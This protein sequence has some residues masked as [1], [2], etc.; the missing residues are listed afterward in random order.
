MVDGADET[1]G[2]VRTAH[3]LSISD[4]LNT[5]NGGIYSVKG[6]FHNPASTKLVSLSFEQTHDMP[7]DHQVAAFQE[8]THSTDVAEYARQLEAKYHVSFSQ[9][10]ETARVRTNGQIISASAHAPT[11]RELSAVE[12]A[13]RNDPSGKGVKFYFLNESL[14]KDPSAAGRYDLDVDGHPSVFLMPRWDKYNYATSAERKQH[15]EGTMSQE[16]LHELAHH[17]HPFKQPEDLKREAENW[18][19]LGWKEMSNGEWA[20]A[21]RDGFYYE[22]V[23]TQGWPDRFL[24]KNAQGILVDKSGKAS[25]VNSNMALVPIADVLDV[26]KIRP[27][28]YYIP[29]PIEVEAEALSVY[30]LDR[31]G[32]GVLAQDFKSLYDQTKKIDQADIDRMYPPKNGRSTKIRS[33]EGPIVDNTPT[34]LARVAQFEKEAANTAMPLR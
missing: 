14:V 8:R 25:G 1:K 22:P 28:N 26:A 34:N 17:S 33:P 7:G 11:V 23:N 29:H 5:S 15:E 18:Q 2:K 24:R 31:T 10:G 30:R 19:S 6:A 32:R 13:L 20:I 27:L 3:E 9:D 12:E 4:S 16:V 21:G